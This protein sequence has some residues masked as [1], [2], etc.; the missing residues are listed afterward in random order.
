MRVPASLYLLGSIVLLLASGRAGAADI[1]AQVAAGDGFEVSSQSGALVRLRV[2]DDGSVLIPGLPSSL[3][4]ESFLCFDATSGQLGL[5]PDVPAGPAG[6]P[7]PPGPQG[8]QGIPGP[9]GA[10][11][12]EGPVGPTGPAGAVGDPGPQGVAGPQGLPG[13]TG[14]AGPAGPQGPIG[15]TGADG[16]PGATGAIGPIGPQGPTG[17]T[18]PA[19]P[20]GPVGP[21]GATEA[22]GAIGPIGPQG[23]TG[24]TGPAGPIG[25]AGATGATGPAGPAGPIGAIGPAGPQGLAGNPGPQGPIGPAGATGPAGPTGPQG[26]AGPAG[27]ANINGTTNS[28]IKFGSGT[29]GV[30]SLATSNAVGIGIGIGGGGPAFPMDAASAAAR[31]VNVVTTLPAG[32]GIWG[33]NTSAAGTGTGAGVV[34]LTAQ[35]NAL[36]AGVY[37][38]NTNVNGTGVIGVGNNVGTST[39]TAGSGG[40][41]GGLTTGVF[42]RSTASG[43]SQAVYA[44]NFGDVVRVNYWNGSTSFKI[45]GIGT[46][47]TNVKDRTDPAGER[48]VHLYAPE[49]P[50]ILFQ[51]YGEGRLQN[52]RARITLDPTFAG[53]VDISDANPLR[54]FIQVEDDENVLGV[55]VKNKSANGFDVVELGRGRSNAP[56][57]WQVICNRADETTQSGRV[58]RNASARFGVVAESIEPQQGQSKQNGG[59]Q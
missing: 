31:T 12:P 6:P 29:T 46:V 59:A 33:R 3:V 57:Q 40:A 51:D 5:C 36:A 54:V 37:G 49:A 56:F 22:T 14:P 13:E 38:E 9:E 43:A 1:E 50:E 8:V 27:T 4:E 34:G 45:S 10:I 26:V 2:N 11:G 53:A 52:G 44:D 55:V 23:P 47:A 58:S 24:D 19:G 35:A 25:P 20:I 39:L 41:F 16:P 42:A 30:D 28:L 18:G 48:R 21:I 32:D 15:A 7:G 17:D